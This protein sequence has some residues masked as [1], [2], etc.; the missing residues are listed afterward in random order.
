MSRNT[1][2]FC[3]SI[4]RPGADLYAF[5]AFFYGL[6]VDAVDI[7]NSPAVYPVQRRAFVQRDRMDGVTAD[8]GIGVAAAAG[9]LGRNIRIQCTWLLY[10]SR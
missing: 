4:C 8:I 3:D 6:V 2:A 1:K 10:T 7:Q 5:S 9:A